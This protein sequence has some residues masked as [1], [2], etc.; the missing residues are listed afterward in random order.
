MRR[1]SHQSRP[2]APSIAMPTQLS[3]ADVK[4]MTTPGTDEHFGKAS[5]PDKDGDMTGVIFEQNPLFA[6]PTDV[7]VDVPSTDPDTVPAVASP[8]PEPLKM[9][10]IETIELAEKE[11]PQ[12]FLPPNIGTDD[13]PDVL[14]VETVPL[15]QIVGRARTDSSPFDIRFYTPPEVVPKRKKRKRW[16][17]SRKKIGYF[18]AFLLSLSCMFLVLLYGLKFDIAALEAA[19]QR[20]LQLGTTTPVNN[21]NSTAIASTGAWNGKWTVSARW[22]FSCAMSDVQDIFINRPLRIILSSLFSFCCAAA[23]HKC[24]CGLCGCG[25]CGFD[26]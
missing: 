18:L 13:K 8:E 9:P 21:G 4:A 10:S 12:V 17:Q 5:A 23:M 15:D 26:D 7:S 24:G 19:E 16:P 3:A 14:V 25:L 22:I 2:M 20:E 11:G 6:D 1:M